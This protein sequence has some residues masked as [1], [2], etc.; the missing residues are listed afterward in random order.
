MPAIQCQNCGKVIEV[1]PD[2]GGA[3]FVCIACGTRIESPLIGQDAGAWVAM[4]R[5]VD[6]DVAKWKG[7][8]SKQEIAGTEE[9]E[10][11]AVVGMMSAAQ[12]APTAAPTNIPSVKRVHFASPLAWAIGIVLV[13]LAIVLPF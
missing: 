5:L 8:D 6:K 2:D 9:A 12:A 13:T 11:A 7:I 1:R 4:R 10:L 3:I